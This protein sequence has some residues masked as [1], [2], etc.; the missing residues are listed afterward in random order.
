MKFFYTLVLLTVLSWPAYTQLK[1]KP[2]LESAAGFD[3]SSFYLLNF[4]LELEK[5][6][7]IDKSIS[8][9][10]FYHN[11]EF[12]FPKNDYGFYDAFIKG[13]RKEKWMDS[14][15]D[16]RV[17]FNFIS[18]PVSY[19]QYLSPRTY[20]SYKLGFNFF[21]TATYQGFY[22]VNSDYS[23]TDYVFKDQ[24]PRE[25]FKK[26]YVSHNISI[27]R[28]FF[29]RLDLGLSFV[30]TKSSFFRKLDADIYRTF[31]REVSRYFAIGL[32]FKFFIFQINS[33]K[34]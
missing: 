29:R 12:N 34:I 26:F 17:M 14:I 13:T 22:T 30:F 2:Q 16:F 25:V 10:I 33:K 19:Q 5:K 24:F 15:T 32:N 20:L 27:N 23:N 8:S 4:G 9:G 1:F 11:F 6:F 3:K 28:I 18:I 21:S 7:D 31:N